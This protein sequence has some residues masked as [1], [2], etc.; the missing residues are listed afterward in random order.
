MRVA[1][2]WGGHISGPI[3]AVAAIALGILSA[4]FADNPG[5]GVMVVKISAWLTA[6]LA[7]ILIMVAQYDAWSAERDKYDAEAAR[8]SRPEIRGEVRT[9]IVRRVRPDQHVSTTFPYAYTF[10]AA[11]CNHR[12]VETNLSRVRVDGLTVSPP[13]VLLFH[14]ISTVQAEPQVRPSEIMLKYG[15]QTELLITAMGSAPTE[16]SNFSGLDISLVD[17]L[18]GTHKLSVQTGLEPIFSDDE[19]A[20]EAL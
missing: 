19:S 11:V 12:S 4:I 15:I 10:F 13:I 6:V 20:S 16:G 18:G 7:A 9:I 5:A 17:G 3:L 8:N 14:E 2:L 1:K